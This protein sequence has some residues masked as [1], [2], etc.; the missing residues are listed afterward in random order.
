MYNVPYARFLQL[1]RVVSS[2]KAE[3]LKMRLR[4]QAYLGWLIV[5]PVAGKRG[6]DFQ[7]WLGSLGLAEGKGKGKIE[8]EDLKAMRKKSLEIA[9]KI[10]E[11]DKNR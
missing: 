6:I 7:E 8:V 1:V 4:E 3:E 10:I 2:Q 11:M 5:Q 9:E